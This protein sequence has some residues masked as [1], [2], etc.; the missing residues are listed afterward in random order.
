MYRVLHAMTVP[1]IKVVRVFQRGQ[2]TRVRFDIFVANPDF[3]AAI[4]TIVG[5]SAQHSW[6]ARQHVPFNRRWVAP[7]DNDVNVATMGGLRVVSLNINGMAQK[8]AELVLLAQQQGWDV[9]LLQETLFSE[10][11]GFALRI[12]GYT[13][14]STPSRAGH[15][16]RGVA[17]AVRNS[18]TSIA[19]HVGDN[20][21]VVRLHAAASQL[22]VASVYV[23]SKAVMARKVVIHEIGATVRGIRARLPGVP[24]I[25]GGDF[26]ADVP[27]AIKMVA[28]WRTD[29][30]H[31]NTMGSPVTWH[32]SSKNKLWSAIDHLFVSQASV[33][34]VFQ[35][36]VDRSVDLSD[37]FPVVCHTSL[38]SI[39]EPLPLV[40]RT[41][42]TLVHDKVVANAERIYGHVCF[43]TL[44]EDWASL[45]DSV[46]SIDARCGSLQR[47][48][49]EVS[50]ELGLKREQKAPRRWAKLSRSTKSL[51]QRRRDFSE[52]LSKKARVLP[53][54]KEA[55][56]VLRK[57]AR[58]AVKA[59]TRASWLRYVEQAVSAFRRR[60]YRRLWQWFRTAAQRGRSSA[61]ST[62]PMLD[63][64]GTLQTAPSEILRVW[65]DHYAALAQDVSGHSRDFAY[66]EVLEAEPSFELEGEALEQLNADVSYDE[67]VVVLRGLASRKAPG[68]SGITCDFFKTVLLSVDAD[69]VIVPCSLGNL[70][71]E[72]VQRMISS[73][74]VCPQQ[75]LA[76]IISIFKGKGDAFNPSDYRGISLMD[77]VL[78]IACTLV[79]RRITRVLEGLDFIVPEQAGFR[80]REESMAH[81]VALYEI[82]IRRQIRGLGTSI[83]FLDF[84]K[85][86][87]TVPHGAL[88]AKLARA[89]I[90]GRVYDFLKAVYGSSM[91][92]VVLPFGSSDPVALLRGVRQGCPGSPCLFNVFINDLPAVFSDGVNVPYFPLALRSTAALLFADD[93]AV[94]AETPAT[95]QGSLAE[96]EAW[97]G[98]YEMT[99][100]VDK[101]G[102]LLIA[103]PDTLDL[104]NHEFRLQ[105]QQV[106]VVPSYRYLGMDFNDK[107]DLNLM[108]KARAAATRKALFSVK[109]F[110]GAT[111]TPVYLRLM[112]LRGSVYGVANFGGELLGMSASRAHYIQKVLDDG[113]RWLAGLRASC[114]RTSSLVLIMEFGL[115]SMA[116]RMNG[117]R[118]RAFLK[119]GE[120]SKTLI[121]DLI[122]HNPSSRKQSWVSGTKSWLA[123]FGPSADRVALECELCD[124]DQLTHEQMGHLVT[125]VSEERLIRAADLTTVS[126]HNYLQSGFLATRSF[127]R[128]AVSLPHLSMGVTL[129]IQARTGAL[130]TGKFMANAGL[131][132]DEYKERCGCCKRMVPET[133]AHVVLQCSKWKKERRAW[134][135]PL[136]DSIPGLSNLSMSSQLVVLLGGS[137]VGSGLRFT[138]WAGPTR[139]PIDIPTEDDFDGM[140][141]ASIVGDRAFEGEGDSSK[142]NLLSS[143]FAMM[144][145][146]LQEIHS[147]RMKI[148]WALS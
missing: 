45:G 32:G 91:M 26:N 4:T 54:D 50:A 117:A 104:D 86:F 64:N 72:L 107:L 69:G 51:I 140:D 90:T 20:L 124:V 63:I 83:C 122:M 92:S 65:G 47:A 48:C 146:F 10:D 24:L 57:E 100:G 145:R 114:R 108:A 13:V 46:E 130:L 81:V 133:I 62:P 27:K 143:P 96:A 71:L 80:V 126:V 119:W 66:W 60:D 42:V 70:L 125:S 144:A 61:R 79:S 102:A 37:H 44:S 120:S 112:A 18:I 134:L 109:G 97:A 129:L 89:G 116:S 87:D 85:A 101:C 115:T 141:E 127:I 131:L 3:G 19:Q 17:V 16:K 128:A 5:S 12:P 95:L 121:H 103:E 52:I 142:E 29:M 22:L 58:L 138:A 113:L 118:A 6:Y 33:G 68:Q 55:L 98:K 11:N 88:F 136:L 21:V 43:A 147:R 84:Q 76:Q 111:S 56:R 94:L 36:R 59:D 135:K 25:L 34:A 14:V 110:L 137:D 9:I 2:A 148:L 7:E 77:S 106:P 78:K 23:P 8:K 74:H 93:A 73:A 41:S 139:S 1:V 123:R 67:L 15:G 49:D 28:G 99:F 39:S 31:M 38:L 40:P 30:V 132:D 75:R 82:C 105:G 35:V 53:E